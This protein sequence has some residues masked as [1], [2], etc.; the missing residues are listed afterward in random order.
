MRDFEELAAPLRANPERA[1]EI[2]WE[3]KV[4]RL[5]LAVEDF[6]NPCARAPKSVRYQN[7]KNAYEDLVE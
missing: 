1:A 2:A 5:M 3:R 4:A 6:L 7:L